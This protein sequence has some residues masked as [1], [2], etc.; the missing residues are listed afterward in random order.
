MLNTEKIKELEAE[1]QRLKA[2]DQEFLAQATEC[3][4]ATALHEI[5]CQHNHIDA[6]SWHYEFDNKTR[7]PLWD[8]HAHGHYLKKA[9]A[10]MAS[11]DRLGI[12]VKNV[13]EI[14]NLVK[15]HV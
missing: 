2:S 13:I 1:I 8:R 10:L 14:L 11:C 7:S 9:H 5:F 12:Q 3:Q 4:L 15:S 6:C